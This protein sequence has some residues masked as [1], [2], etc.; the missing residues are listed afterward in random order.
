[1]NW[2][3][4]RMLTGDAQKFY[5]LLFGI[6]FST[7]LITQQLTIFV[8]LLERGSSGVYNV[9]SADV[10]VMDPVSRTTDVAYPMPSTALDKV[11]GVPGV[12]W[13]VPHIRANANVRTSDGDLEGVA[14]IGVDDATLIGLPR[15]MAEGSAEVLSQPDSVIIDDVGVTRMF[16]DGGALGQRLELND[17]RAVIRGV[18]DAIPSFTSTV[19]LYTKYSQ[20]LNYVPGTRNRLSFVLVGKADDITAQQLVDRIEAQT[21]LKA[22][23]RDQFASDGVQFIVENTGIPLNFGITVALGFIVGVAIVGLTF[24]LFIRD[25]IKQFGALKAIGVT[26]GKI[27][28]MVAV[29][30]GM[31]GFIGYG[32]GVLGTVLF[33]LAFSGNPTFKGFYIPWQIPLIS[34]VAIILIIALTGWLALRSVMKTEPAAVFR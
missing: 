14:V 30:A 15:G 3:A 1:M 26:N 29:Q 31:V 25:N 12:A 33:I 32:L 17:Q 4:I 16:P 5:G 20:A 34:L 21:G 28:R 10:W 19:V 8:N 22:R 7:L 2:I 23:T 9:S 24:S 6:A 27:R 13:A 11:R 18:A